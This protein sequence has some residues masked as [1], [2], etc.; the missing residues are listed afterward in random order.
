M[1]YVTGQG[2]R[3]TTSDTGVESV[4]R[5][6]AIIQLLY[7]KLHPVKA[8]EIS[9]RL[10]LPL[11]ST[12]GILRELER[13]GWIEAAPDGFVA[14]GNIVGLADR[15]LRGKTP[16]AYLVPL[17][18]QLRDETQE[19]AQLCILSGREVVV[20]AAAQG[21]QTI[22]VA[23][24][25]GR[26]SPVNW[27]AAGRVLLTAFDDVDLAASLDDMIVPSPTGKAPTSGQVLLAQ[28]QDTRRQGHWCQIGE[29][30]D[31]TGAIAAPIVDGTDQCVAAMSIVA[32]EHR[33]RDNFD[34]LIERLQAKT[35]EASRLVR[36]SPCS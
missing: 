32:P 17:V 23:A 5:A 22:S 21:L 27:L 8:R 31:F 3:K 20:V 25:V 11:S 33:L 4:R 19:T 13:A 9:N 28:V 12:Y 10:R 30:A 29:A 7:G 26:R 6:I 36:Q 15:A 34:L 16:L 2:S 24:E 35:S 1:T 18:Q 14:T